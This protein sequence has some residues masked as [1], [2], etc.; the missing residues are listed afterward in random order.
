MTVLAK[1]TMPAGRQGPGRPPK[2]KG[3]EATSQ[4]THGLKA[5]KPLA[6]KHVAHTA[7]ISVAR[8]SRQAERLLGP[9]AYGIKDFGA[10]PYSIKYLADELRA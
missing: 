8:K 5:N 1:R 9:M 7:I 4:E 3:L 10:T 2:A 6:G